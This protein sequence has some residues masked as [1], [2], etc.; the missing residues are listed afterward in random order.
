MRLTPFIF[1]L[2]LMALPGAGT[3][4]ALAGKR[5][6][7]CNFPDGWNPTDFHRRTLNLPPDLHHLCQ[8]DGRGQIVDSHGRPT[9]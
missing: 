5:V 6:A 8:I 4:P 9:T 2:I 1:I 3:S 7:P